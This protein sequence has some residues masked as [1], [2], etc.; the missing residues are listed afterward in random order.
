MHCK[1]NFLS[2]LLLNVIGDASVIEAL[3][4]LV[5]FLV[6]MLDQKLL[7]TYPIII[8]KLAICFYSWDLINL[9]FMC[10]QTMKQRTIEAFGVFF[11]SLFCTSCLSFWVTGFHWL[12][13]LL[14]ARVLLVRI[15]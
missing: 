5:C 13:V 2:L 7:S 1:K 12:Q 9:L 3:P 10:V 11:W 4:P 14:I 6:F 8:T 15:S